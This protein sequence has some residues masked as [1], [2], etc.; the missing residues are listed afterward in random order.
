MNWL[1]RCLDFRCNASRARHD[2]IA[3]TAPGMVDREISRLLHLAFAP[4]TNKAYDS[5][6]NAFCRFVQSMQP[7][8]QVMV[9]SQCICEFIAW[10]S[11]QR[12]SPALPLSR[13]VA[14]ATTLHSPALLQT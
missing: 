13:T 12:Y 11:L 6:W 7:Q 10:L 3:H 5:G 14:D 1:M 8:D 9:N 4:N 2:S